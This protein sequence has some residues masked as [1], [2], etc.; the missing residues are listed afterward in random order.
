MKKKFFL[1]LGILFFIVFLV[2]EI[3][4]RNVTPIINK[5]DD[6]LGWKLLPNLDLEFTQKTLLKKKYTVKF[7]TN[8]R[9]SR[10]YG[11]EHDAEIKI[12]V[13]GDSGTGGPYASNDLMWFSIL[14]KDL[15]AKLNKKIYVEAIGSGGYGNFQQYLLSK[16]IKDIL[17]PDL[18]IL[19]FCSNDFYNNSYEW[20]S[21]GITRNQYVRRPYLVNNK[22]YYHQ[23]FLKY[24]YNSF[25]FENI[26]LINRADLLVTLLQA[27]ITNNF[28]GRIPGMNY[29]K[30]DATLLEFQKNSVVITDII[31]SKI[32]K[33][34]SNKDLFV[35]NACKTRGQYPFN[36]W[37]SIST[38]NELIPLDFYEDI[39]FTEESY[40]KDG[41]HLN[42][43]GNFSVG[44]ELSNILFHYLK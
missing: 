36:T 2:T 20:E 43:R 18:I 25:L 28:F 17:N 5:G 33:Q 37:I 30:N 1:I 44:K 31:L 35:F 6:L 22:I 14:A 11:N 24:I 29:A 26:R 3:I 7:L 27:L 19:Q 38:K 40:Y 9:G 23:G 13:M 32:K 8:A 4:I 34:F 10:Y 42:E 16:E 15:Q 21:S 39:K 41:G 12:L